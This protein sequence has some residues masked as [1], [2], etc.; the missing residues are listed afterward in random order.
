MSIVVESITCS[1]GGRTVLQDVSLSL[2]P[3]RLLALVGP[4]GAGKSTLLA[5]M[6]GD[7]DLD[8]GSVAVSG[9]PLAD[10]HPTE[11]ARERSVLL[12]SNEV[13]FGF[14]ARQVVEM[15]RS[16]WTRQ[17]EAADDEA[18]VDSALATT[19]VTHLADRSFRSLS[20]G[21]R[22]RVGLARVLA[23]NTPTVLLDEPTAALDLRHQE[24]VM[25]LARSLAHD[26]RAVA[27]VVHDLSLAAAYADE[28]AVVVDGRLTAHGPPDEVLT[29]E[30]V[31]AVYGVAVHRVRTPDGHTVLVPHRTQPNR[32][33]SKETS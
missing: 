28:V 9:R 13:S 29:E 19:D 8:S 6:C 1:R 33:P 15:G 17:P 4:N 25:R 16:P 21:E 23:Q 32:A 14:T 10:W 26:G 31:E 2:E 3:G 24:E 5:A 7:I 12:Q 27:V 22:A 20:G 18:I 30:T 11:L